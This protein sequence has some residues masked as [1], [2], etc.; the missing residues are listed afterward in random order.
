MID[1]DALDDVLRDLHRRMSKCKSGTPESAHISN[2]IGP[3]THLYRHKPINAIHEQRLREMLARAM[4]AAGATPPAQ[5][6]A[7]GK[8]G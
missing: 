7:E 6:T 4:R 2:L 5:T 8:E 1:R 3:L